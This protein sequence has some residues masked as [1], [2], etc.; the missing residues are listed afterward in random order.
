MPT[1]ISNALQFSH[2]SRLTCTINGSSRRANSHT[3]A[4]FNFFFFN[5]FKVQD[6]LD[7]FCLANI[8]ILKAVIVLGPR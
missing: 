3:C 4:F 1:F 6:G 8:D 2:V 7:D 5:I